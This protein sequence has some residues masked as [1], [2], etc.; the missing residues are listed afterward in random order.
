MGAQRVASRALDT[1]TGAPMV[2]SALALDVV[3]GKGMLHGAE[4]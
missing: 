4:V 1:A 2:T 3:S